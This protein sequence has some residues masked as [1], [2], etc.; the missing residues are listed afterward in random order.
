FVEALRTL[1]NLIDDTRY[2]TRLEN[3]R[4]HMPEENIQVVFFEDLVRDPQATLANCLKFIGARPDIMPIALPHLNDGELK[5]RDT[6]PMR[7]LRECPR[8]GP[9]LGRIPLEQQDRFAVP[10]G[11]RRRHADSALRA[12]R[13]EARTYVLDR[14][15]DECRRLL[16]W[17][18][19]PPDFWPSLA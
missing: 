7:W 13:S 12:D 4:R 3:Y 17:C 14:L 8:L 9:R 6:R 18:G 2:W 16:A 11:L 1:P 10:L 15:G 19:K 5:R